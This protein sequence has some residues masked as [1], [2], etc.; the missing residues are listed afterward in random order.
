MPTYGPN[1]T[2]TWTDDNSYGTDAWVSV[3]NIQTENGINSYVGIS[4]QYESSHYA[5]GH[6]FGFSI[7]SD[8]AIVGIQVDVKARS[9]LALDTYDVVKLIKNGSVVGSNLAASTAITQGVLTWNT[10][11]GASSLWG[12]SWLYSDINASNFG[13]VCSV[14]N[15][16]AGYTQKY[17]DCIRITVYTVNTYTGDS[18][19]SVSSSPTLS[20]SVAK[21]TNTPNFDFLSVQHSRNIGDTVPFADLSGTRWDRYQRDGHLNDAIRKWLTLQT[22]GALIREMQ[23][24]DA[25]GYWNALS[26]YVKE[27]TVSLANNVGSLSGVSHVIA[28]YDTNTG[29]VLKRLPESGASF[30][31]ASAGN[32]FLTPNVLNPYWTIDGGNIR[33]IDGTTGSTDALGVRYVAEHVNLASFGTTD[34]AIPANYWHQILDLAMMFAKEENNQLAIAQTKDAHVKKEISGE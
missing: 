5:N 7:P 10:F 18:S 24:I 26:S 3:T 22:S 30:A 29:V 4:T 2:A 33:L 20:C 8:K 23:G 12:T 21:L 13:V 14:K 34:I 28:V 11:G 27:A 32:S 16:N 6:G 17:I 19:I 31:I 9:D 15:G 25:S 1:T